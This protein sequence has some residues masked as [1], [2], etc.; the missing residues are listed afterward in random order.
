MTGT[1]AVG[2]TEGPRNHSDLKSLSDIDPNIILLV[3]CWMGGKKKLIF[4]FFKLLLYDFLTLV[5]LLLPIDRCWWLSHS[6]HEVYPKQL[7]AQPSSPPHA[8]S[9]WPQLTLLTLSNIKCW[10]KS[11]LSLWDWD[12]G[13][14]VQDFGVYRSFCWHHY[15]SDSWDTLD[16]RWYFFATIKN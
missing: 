16:T 10:H 1:W 4:F 9:S 6:Q 5:V 8:S 13:F 12:Y 2:M 14:Y 15:S 11:T 3:V 7:S